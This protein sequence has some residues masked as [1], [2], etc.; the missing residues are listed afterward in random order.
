MKSLNFSHYLLTFVGITETISTNGVFILFNLLSLIL[1]FSQPLSYLFKLSINFNDDKISFI[2]T[3]I[4]YS[5]FSNFLTIPQSFLLTIIFYI[6]LIS[7]I[8]FFMLFWILLSFISQ[9]HEH[10]KLKTLLNRVSFVFKWMFLVF[11][12]FF[13]IPSLDVL[14]N[15]LF[16]LGVDGFVDCKDK[17]SFPFAIVSIFYILLIILLSWIYLFFG[18]SFSFN[19]VN[20][21]NF[22]YNLTYLWIFI[23]RII[24]PLIFPILNSS[25]PVFFY[26]I[27]ILLMIFLFVEYLHALP[28]RNNRF[29]EIYGILL[30]STILYLFL[31][32]SFDFFSFITDYSM[33]YILLLLVIMAIKSGQVLS[34]R[35]YFIILT[36]PNQKNLE[37]SLEEVDQLFLKH[38]D[39]KISRFNFYGILRNH[40]KTCQDKKC[41]FNS[42]NL[43][44]FF[45]ANYFQKEHIINVFITQGLYFLITQKEFINNETL[46]LKYVSFLLDSKITPYKAYFEFQK[47]KQLS[48]KKTMYQEI[49][50]KY[51]KKKLGDK[52]KELAKAHLINTNRKNSQKNETM[53]TST[54]FD[55][56]QQGERFYN[57]A[58]ELFQHKLKVL[59]NYKQGFSSYDEILSVLSNFFNKTNEYK[60]NLDNYQHSNNNIFYLKYSSLYSCIIFNN[61]KSANQSEDEFENLKKKHSK[62]EGTDLTPLIFLN[63]NLVTCQASFLNIEGRIL[64]SSKTEKFARFFNYSYSE[65]RGLNKVADLMPSMLG[66]NHRHFMQW[67]L[68][69]EWNSE[70][71]KNDLIESFGIEKNG[72]IFPIKIFTGFDLRDPDDFV[73][74]A[75]LMKLPNF[76]EGVYFEKSG[77]VIGV[78]EGFFRIFHEINQQIKLEGLESLNVFNLIEGLKQIINLHFEQDKNYE[79][80]ISNNSGNIVVPENIK[81]IIEVLLLK[82]TEIVVDNKSSERIASGKSLR[83]FTKTLNSKSSKITEKS[84]NTTKI[85]KFLAKSTIGSTLKNKKDLILLISFCLKL[86]K[87]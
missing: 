19:D 32:I 28:F 43:E 1:L 23:F 50:Q 75:G 54:F 21:I 66:D 27:F 72:F 13:L 36:Q 87:V 56:S 84:I 5:N 49:M 20:S 14:I 62:S 51:V 64:E 65:L 78:T 6:I 70:I 25:F 81:E 24:I 45:L 79:L 71:L 59:E 83:S 77:A 48:M 15:P 80:A 58:M 53:E 16:C 67:R 85:S 46:I 8:T 7:S 63:T 34:F 30:F 9:K 2:N 68:K 61:L 22:P 10:H 42:A 26:A 86:K 38:Q 55:L 39:D 57:L 35:K 3:I 41:R 73:L 52:I 33:F 60:K 17:F 18:R 29:N 74:Y 76:G 47:T 11:N 40:K 12:R 69:R 37:F 4:Y 44:K 31:T 82:K